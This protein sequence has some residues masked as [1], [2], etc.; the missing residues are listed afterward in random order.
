MVTP[1]LRAHKVFLDHLDRLALLVDEEKL[2]PEEPQE[3]KVPPE[4][5]A[6]QELVDATDNLAVEEVKENK[7][8]LET[9][10]LQDHRDPG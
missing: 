8:A 2:V 5:E 3:S 6:F 1:D 7:V 10:E 9:L 4:L